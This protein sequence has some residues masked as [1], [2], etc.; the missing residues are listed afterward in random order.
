MHDIV[1]FAL[2]VFLV[3]AFIWF[4]VDRYGST[5][6]SSPTTTPTRSRAQPPHVSR[7]GHATMQSAPPTATS[8]QAVALM[9]HAAQ[10]MVSAT[11]QVQR[12]P[13]VAE[14]AHLRR[15]TWRSGF[16][17][18]TFSRHV[19]EGYERQAF[20]ERLRLAEEVQRVRHRMEVRE[21]AHVG[22]L[23]AARD[24]VITDAA[25]RQGQ[26][27]QLA[28]ASS[29]AR[30]DHARQRV[31]RLKDAQR[32]RNEQ[33]AD[34]DAARSQRWEDEQL[35]RPRIIAEQRFQA[36][37]QERAHSE[38]RTAWHDADVLRA[39][40][41]AQARDDYSRSRPEEIASQQFAIEQAERAREGTRR[42]WKDEDNAPQVQ[43]AEAEQQKRQ[44]ARDEARARRDAKAE[45]AA[46][47]RAADTV[48]QQQ[49]AQARQAASDAALLE[50]E[51]REAAKREARVAKQDRE[52]AARARAR[53]KEREERAEARRRA[54]ESDQ[55]IQR[56]REQELAA[57]KHQIALRELQA[58]LNPT[59]DV[60][61]PPDPAEEVL[62]RECARIALEVS[63][64]AVLTDDENLYHAFAAIKFRE[65][66][67][68]SATS[69]EAQRCTADALFKRRWKQPEITRAQADAF[70]A[71]YAHMLAAADEQEGVAQARA[72]LTTVMQGAGDKY[73][74]K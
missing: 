15:E 33:L 3:A 69:D 53:G 55:A 63:T 35:T 1:G 54:A 5:L 59:R 12:L 6:R 48:R 23:G 36:E 52:T 29:E 58:R 67:G 74:H 65:F 27:A 16:P 28:L 61:P 25:R 26:A 43:R 11:P 68:Q 57:I 10:S 4:Y 20:L 21:I 71:R 44:R 50:R 49:Q 8:S 14:L 7:P 38:M 24:A 18:D 13:A 56:A 66:L 46:Q 41:Q 31:W 60:P 73:G 62:R 9:P 45:A 17:E 47:K 19:R 64:G 51:A 22:E 2:G 70:A 34:H 37:V 42:A 32:T 72:L 30:D 39:Q 40:Q